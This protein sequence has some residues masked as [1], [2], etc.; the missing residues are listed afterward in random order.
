[1]NG[2]IFSCRYIDSL[3]TQLKV[4]ETAIDEQ[5]KWLEA[6]RDAEADRLKV[7]KKQLEQIVNSIVTK[8]SGQNSDPGGVDNVPPTRHGHGQN[9]LEK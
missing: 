6:N 5:T 7:H 2:L 4:I 3:T 8:L 1:M 9:S